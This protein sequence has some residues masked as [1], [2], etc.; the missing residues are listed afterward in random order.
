MTQIKFHQLIVPTAF[1]LTAVTATV[2]F[3]QSDNH[4]PQCEAKT[5]DLSSLPEYAQVDDFS[6]DAVLAAPA[7]TDEDGDSLV[8]TDISDNATI[9]GP[10][11][12]IRLNQRVSAG[13]SVTVNFT[14]SDGNGGTASSSITVKR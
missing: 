2:A 1:L 4:A 3:A 11:S 14:V 7:C 9:N 10:A 12:T 8:L 13:E 5:I 6:I